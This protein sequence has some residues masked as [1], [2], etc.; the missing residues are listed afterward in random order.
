MYVMTFIVYDVIETAYES[1]AHLHVTERAVTEVL[2]HATSDVELSS[3]TASRSISTAD[4]GDV[5]EAAASQSSAALDSDFASATFYTATKQPEY[6]TSFSRL[7]N[8]ITT[9][10]YDLERNGQSP[11]TIAPDL[12]SDEE[13]WTSI[14]PDSGPACT[15]KLRRIRGS[16]LVQ[17]K[18]T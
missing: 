4:T 9:A 13:Q 1:S 11:S 7:D 2:R 8:K 3:P 17:Y 16:G 6:S 15:G 12:E 5:S 18:R 14:D 10:N